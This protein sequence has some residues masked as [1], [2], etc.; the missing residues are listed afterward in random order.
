[1]EK[2]GLSPHIKAARYG[3]RGEKGYHTTSTY[4]YDLQSHDDS[5]ETLR[6]RLS[7]SKPRQEVLNRRHSVT[8]AA[9]FPI[10]THNERFMRRGFTGLMRLQS[11]T[12]SQE[13]LWLR[14]NT[15]KGSRPRRGTPPFKKLLVWPA[16]AFFSLIGEQY[17]P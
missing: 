2:G 3:T 12:F 13:D 6:S 16:Y 15:F 9:L 1:M 17:G 7:Y 8:S 10:F 11:R 4:L 14:R 5:S